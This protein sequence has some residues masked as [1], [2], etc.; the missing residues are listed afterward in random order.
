M[1]YK[2]LTS[3]IYFEG[4]AFKVRVDQVQ[5]STG[6]VMH[7]EVVEHRGA[8]VLVPIEDDGRIVF[9]KQ[10]R[11]PTGKILL[12]LPAGT[13]DPHEDPESCAIREC[14]EEIGMAPG[15]IARIGG[16]YLAPGYS[17]EYLDIYLAQEMSPAPLDPDEDEDLEIE[18][19]DSHQ[20]QKKI[21][22]GIIEDA[23]TLA[24]LYLVS[25]RFTN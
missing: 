16:F 15:K 12:E 2:V 20:I 25:K 11:H 6:Q 14:R 10:Y 24:S 8:V 9:V 23:K 18:R 5:T 3:E 21:E 1:K 22:A 7:V 19:L 4:R 17:T 13:L